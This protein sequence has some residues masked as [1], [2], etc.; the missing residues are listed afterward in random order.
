MRHPHRRSSFQKAV[1][2]SPFLLLKP[3]LPDAI[4]EPRYLK[5]CT[6]LIV[7][8]YTSSGGCE[9]QMFTIY[10]VL[11]AFSLIPTSPNSR[12]YTVS[13]NNSCNEVPLDF[14]PKWGWNRQIS[15]R[16]SEW[17]PIWSYWYDL[18]SFEWSTKSDHREA[19]A[20]LLIKS[21]ITDW[22]LDD[23]KSSDQLIINSTVSEDLTKDKK[24]VK[25]SEIC[26]FNDFV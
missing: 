25:N 20:D 4:M 2:A 19:R 1:H 16:T 21:M 14:R 10:S 17:S 26:P 3:P 22:I 15:L 24:Q 5:S 8:P 12:G 9:Q 7:V 6:W 11:E 23:T 18:K 13:S